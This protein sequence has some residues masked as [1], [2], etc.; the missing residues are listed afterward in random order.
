MNRDIGSGSGVGLDDSRQPASPTNCIRLV[1]VGLDDPRLLSFVASHPGA[2][3]YHHPAWIKALVAEYD[4][5]TVVLASEGEDGSLLGI[6]PLMYT[7]GLPI[8]IGGNL[9]SARLSSLPRTPIAGPLA[10]SRDVSRMLLVAA[11]DRVSGV[12][13]LRLQIKT[14]GPIM[15]G[16]I[17]GI[18]G[19]PWR[20]SYVMSL[21][22]DA[23]NLVMKDRSLRKNIKRA[24]A[25]GLTV[26]VATT[27]EDLRKWHSL[28]LRTMRRVVIPPRSLRYFLAAWKFLGPLNL[29][30]VFLA[31]RKVDGKTDLIAGLIFF[32]YK[33]RFCAGFLACPA[34]H[35]HFRPNDLIHWE[36]IQ[37]ATSNGYHEYDF[38]EVP[39]GETELAR[40]KMK[41]GAVPRWLYRYYYPQ[42]SAASMDSSKLST[43]QEIL[44]RCWKRV[45]LPATAFLGD[46]IYSYM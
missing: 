20:K 17:N 42:E 24:A 14:E 22:R 7:R 9:S 25:S 33:E 32:M 35:F 19:S 38:G 10:I 11:L 18:S 13:K 43:H 39:E 1:E 26:R 6:L 34:E 41:F 27:E 30:K 4:R 37:W 16:L 5:K 23:A 12:S 2:T 36:A 31:E 44:G 45:P 15:D 40:F 29:M 21:P 28:Y 46:L 8:P 3:V